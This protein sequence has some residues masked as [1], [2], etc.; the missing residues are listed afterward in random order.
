ME[1]KGS[2]IEVGHQ[3]TVHGFCGKGHIWHMIVCKP[4]AYIAEFE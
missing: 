1:M 3:Q 2:E 4:K